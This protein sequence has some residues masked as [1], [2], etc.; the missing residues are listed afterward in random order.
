MGSF[1]NNLRGAVISPGGNAP[2]ANAFRTEIP[3]K[4]TD[5]ASLDKSYSVGLRGSP[6]SIEGTVI[7]SN[8]ADRFVQ[9][10]GSGSNMEV[11]GSPSGV[12]KLKVRNIL[13]GGVDLD[14]YSNRINEMANDIANSKSDTE[15]VNKLSKYSSS[16]DLNKY[17]VS[18]GQSA[19][20]GENS[21]GQVLNKIK[22][23]YQSLSKND[24]AKTP[25]VMEVYSVIKQ[26]LDPYYGLNANES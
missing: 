5:P 18:N 9:N 26:H 22:K 7:G 24:S 19:W 16:W 4:K 11:K 17:L 10:N 13:G 14:R 15:I 3:S 12:T 21:V 20:E 25:T 8:P 2:L 6:Q 23:E 1:I